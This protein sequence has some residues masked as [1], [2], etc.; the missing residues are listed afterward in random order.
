MTGDPLMEDNP[1][2]K[3]KCVR[4]ELT[5][6]QKEAYESYEKE[7]DEWVTSIIKYQHDEDHNT[8]ARVGQVTILE[9][10]SEEGTVPWFHVEIE[11][12]RDV[13]AYMGNEFLAHMKDTLEVV[14]D[15]TYIYREHVEDSFV[16]RDLVKALGGCEIPS[17]NVRAQIHAKLLMA[18]D[19]FWH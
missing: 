16:T 12:S 14:D 4:F 13:L 18:L 7:R 9:E 15:N 5:P 6:E 1:K 10:K 8:N 3:K 19:T 11:V 17:T 2:L